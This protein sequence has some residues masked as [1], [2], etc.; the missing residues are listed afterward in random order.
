MEDVKYLKEIKK[1]LEGK[2]VCIF[3]M[4]LVGQVLRDGLSSRGINIDFFCDNNETLWETSYHG[5]ECI[6]YPQ[7]LEMNPDD[8]VI[9]IAT[10][11]YYEPI[12]EQL[13][14]DGFKN[15]MRIY[16]EKIFAEEY[17]R[18]HKDNLQ[19]RIEQVVGILEDEK[20]RKIYRH[21]TNFWNIENVPDDYFRDICSD[22]QYFDEEIISLGEDEVLVD[23][24]AY[25]GDTAMDFIK[26]SH[27]NYRKMH[28][29]ELDPVI[30]KELLNNAAKLQRE[31]KGIIQCYPYGVSNRNQE[32]TFIH[33]ER[34]SSINNALIAANGKS[35]ELLGQI[36]KLDDILVDEEV[37]FIKMDIEGA[38]H[39]ALEGARKIITSRKPILAICI[40]HSP[41][42]MLELPIYIK[43]LNPEYKIYIRHYTDMM[44]ETVCYAIP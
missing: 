40:Y 25:I 16:F 31:S 43:S 1:Q 24:G 2:K 11:S 39:D 41:K 35:E 32:I 4:G 29:F 28:L 17:V 38:E 7:L 22:N 9:I 33:G 10:G 12:K 36:K 27:G 30:Y 13:F 34:N 20:S 5:T 44:Y 3:A 19:K 23:C 42:D 6:P 26:K 8:V 37:T 18:E 14:R 15:C 21:L